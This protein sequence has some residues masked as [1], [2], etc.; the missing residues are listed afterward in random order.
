MVAT[1][2]T[3]GW[4]LAAETSTEAIPQP[5][6]PKEPDSSQAPIL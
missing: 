1:P 2:K 6:E 4:V 5:V 3:I